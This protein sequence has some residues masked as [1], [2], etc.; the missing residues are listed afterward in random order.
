M[1]LFIFTLGAGLVG[2]LSIGTAVSMN[3]A[4]SA[5]GGGPLVAATMPPAMAAPATMVPATAAPFG[6][7]SSNQPPADETVLPTPTAET[8]IMSV[9]PATP[10]SVARVVQAPAVQKAHH[11]P[12]NLW[13]FIWPGLAVILGT[14][15]LL[16]LWSNKRTFQR[17]NSRG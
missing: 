6:G 13:L 4:P 17:K 11:K 7:G 16:V 8:S 3:A 10:P 1:L 2:Q 5:S 15:A 9:A 14:L 12:L